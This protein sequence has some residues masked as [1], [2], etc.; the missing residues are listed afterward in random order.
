MSFVTTA[1][2]IGETAP[3]SHEIGVTM[4]AH[5][6]AGTAPL[7]CVESPPTILCPS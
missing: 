6:D 3:T 2:S 4:S 5:G 7:I 1:D